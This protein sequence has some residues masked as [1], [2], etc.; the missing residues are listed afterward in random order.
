[1]Q[2]ESHQFHASVIRPHVANGA[3]R[4]LA[5]AVSVAWI[6]VAYS[7]FSIVGAVVCFVAWKISILGLQRMAKADPLMRQVY[8]RSLKYRGYYPAKSGMY[9]KR[10]VP[11]ERWD[12]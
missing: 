9:A 5:I 7:L 2:L 3:D 12:R 6:M 8:L 11:R 10:L 1:M 4:Q